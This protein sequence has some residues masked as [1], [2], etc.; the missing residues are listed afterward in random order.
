[1]PELDALVK[2]ASLGTSGICIFAIFWIGWL[3]QGSS[4]SEN[5]HYHSTLKSYMKTVV[6]IAIIS[7]IS[8][9]GNALIKQEKIESLSAKN[10][11]TEMLLSK[12]KQEKEI[13]LV[14]NIESK[15]TLKLI[16]QSKQAYALR[17][18]DDELKTHIDQLK[19]SLG[20]GLEFQHAMQ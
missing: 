4:K 15:K 13:L 16:I 17:N 10:A 19:S 1:M 14:R 9:I 2:L 6:L 11:H 8:G 5:P 7:S 12:E 3:I 20:T 18:P